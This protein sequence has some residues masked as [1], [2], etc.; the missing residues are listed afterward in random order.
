MKKFDKKIQIKILKIILIIIWMMAIFIFSSQKGT[1]SGNTSR[2]FTIAI[3]QII[4]GKNLAL[5]DP[6]VEG[7]QLF[8]RKLAHFTIYAIGGFLIMNYAYTTEKTMKQKILYSI[9]FGAGYAITDEIH[10]FFVSGRSA[11]VL[12]VAIDTAGVIIGVLI[13]LALRKLAE[14]VRNKNNTKVV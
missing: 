9:A 10:Q 12:D 6:F 14:F 2:K 7:I 11:Q 1:E 4:T 13:Y 3:I 5:E 8:I